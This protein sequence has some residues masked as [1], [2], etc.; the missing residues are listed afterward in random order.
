MRGAIR[1]RSEMFVH[2]KERKKRGN[3]TERKL[4]SR[5]KPFREYSGDG[6]V[7]EHG[8]KKFGVNWETRYF[9]RQ[10]TCLSRSART[11]WGQIAPP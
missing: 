1:N 11:R 2:H 10:I 3:S 4:T 5:H 8:T 9:I 7:G 6:E